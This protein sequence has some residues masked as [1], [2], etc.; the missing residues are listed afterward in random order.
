M[1]PL[2]APAK[3]AP[4]EPGQHN[5][6]TELAD[7]PSKTKPEVGTDGGGR[8]MH[9]A[10]W[11]FGFKAVAT[12]VGGGLL[13]LLIALAQM[14]YST[15]LEILQRQDDQGVEFQNRLAQNLGRIENEFNDIL[16]LVRTDRIGRLREARLRLDTN[17]NELF[18]NW[19]L[20]RLNMRSRASQIYGPTV[21][22]LIYNPEEEMFRLDRCYVTVR[23]DDPARNQNCA[24]R[25][26][27]EGFRLAALV[28]VSRLRPGDHALLNVRWA[29]AS[30]QANAR[31]LRVVFEN[32]VK[33]RLRRAEHPRERPPRQ[34]E[35]IEDMERIV[36]SRLDLVAIAREEISTA[37][38]ERSTLQE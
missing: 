34:C 28:Q 19:R 9:R 2:K 27:R 35:H 3:F 10:T 32:Y 21:G 12:T 7:G 11:L 31:L 38:M 37:I 25:G 15:H 24:T 29:Q 8:T 36:V 13:T 30:F 5:S 6:K 17:L 4:R 22:N 20:I 18:R 16:D 26:R 23:L 33:C 1:A 14:R